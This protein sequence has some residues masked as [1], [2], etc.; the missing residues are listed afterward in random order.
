MKEISWRRDDGGAMMK[1]KPLRRN[2]GGEI[3]TEKLGEEKYGRRSHE[4]K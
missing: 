4:E 3:I 2:T 1:E